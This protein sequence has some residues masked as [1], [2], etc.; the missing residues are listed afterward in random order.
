[1]KGA[2]VSCDISIVTDQY[3]CNSCGACLGSC[4]QNA[5]QFS[6]TLGGYLFPQIDR[7]KCTKCGL[8]YQVCPGAGLGR[9]LCKKLPK[10]PF[11]GDILS[12]DVGRATEEDIF[13]NSQSGGVVTALLQSLFDNGK[14]EAAIVATMCVGDPPRGK[15]MIVRNSSELIHA[16]KSKYTPIP[17]L[18]A[19]REVLSIGGTIALVGLPCHIHGLDN[20]QDILHVF[21]RLDVVKIGL[22]CDRIMLCSAIDF[23]ARKATADTVNNFTFRDKKNGNYPGN[24]VAYKLGGKKIVLKASLRLAIKDFFTPARCRLCFDKMNIFA[25]IVCGDPH[26]ING[27]D[28]KNGETLVISRTQRGKEIIEQAKNGRTVEVRPVSIESVVNGQLVERKKKEWHAYMTAWNG[29]GKNL[30]SYPIEYRTQ[31]DVTGYR[32]RLDHALRIDKYD[33]VF[34]LMKAAD[35]CLLQY[36]VLKFSA[37]PLKALRSVVQAVRNRD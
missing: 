31:S 21:A 29:M 8:C 37:L 32:Q 28:R 27:V 13:A 6:E 10:D 14:I 35:R 7:S 25:D 2:L 24:P 5:I 1:M 11:V 9:A 12:C 34:E 16:Q 18:R 20:L 17:V 4:P 23:M 30:P 33:S 3:L 15:V 36:K 19:L 22:I 26:G